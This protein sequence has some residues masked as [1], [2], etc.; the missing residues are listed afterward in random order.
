M[1]KFPLI[2]GGNPDG[3][4]Y[5]TPK[6]LFD[7]LHSVFHFTVDACASSLNA[8]LPHFWTE[9]D[10]A[11]QQDW[12]NE[13]VFCNPPFR[14]IGPFLAK[15]ATARRAVVLAPCNYLT[16]KPFHEN[17]PDHIIAPWG[18][19]KFVHGNKK[20]HPVLGTAFLIYGPLSAVEQQ[21]LG[22]VCFSLKS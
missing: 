10:D 2:P 4:C 6:P 21:A 22:G 11:L 15:A 18:R 12:T 13:I 8:L 20:V 7:K 5:Q 1:K 14:C 19:V 16:A 17:P 3:Q 9:E